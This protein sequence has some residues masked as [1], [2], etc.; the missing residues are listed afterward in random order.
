[1]SIEIKRYKFTSLNGDKYEFEIEET[2]FSILGNDDEG[3]DTIL[4]LFEKADI[5]LLKELLDKIFGEK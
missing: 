5:P 4:V 1:M 2:Q 3:E